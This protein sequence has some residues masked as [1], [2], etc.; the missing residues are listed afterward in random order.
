ML[1]IKII[2][3]LV[4]LA[5]AGGG[6]LYVTKLQKDNAILKTNQVKLET[7]V[8]E[9]NQVIEQQTKDLKK[10]RSTL[11]EI[12]EQNVK[13]Q[14]DRDAL[15][16]R[17]GK[18]DIGNLAENKPGLVEK[19]INKASDSAAR[20]VEIASGSPLTEEE[21]NGKPNRE[22]PSFWPSDTTSK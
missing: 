3:A 8:A 9:S 16:N 21:L 10:I 5:G 7:A 2:L 11:K 18:H 19:I 14:K 22:C 15:N 1:Q 20:C 4:L 13:L 12:D 17:L 6:Y